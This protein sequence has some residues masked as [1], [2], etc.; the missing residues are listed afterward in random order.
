RVPSRIH[1]DGIGGLV[2]GPVLTTKVVAVNERIS[3]AELFR[4]RHA[5]SL[6]FFCCA[7]DVTVSSRIHGS[8]IAQRATGIGRINN[9]WI[10]DQRLGEIVFSDTESDAAVIC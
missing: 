8:A 7:T 5:R 10:D 1:R 4:E 6:R 9:L 3:R 2:A